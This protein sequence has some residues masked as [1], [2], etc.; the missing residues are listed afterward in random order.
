MCPEVGVCRELK[1]SDLHPVAYVAR[2]LWACVFRCNLFCFQTTYMEPYC[3]DYCWPL[4]GIN[5]AVKESYGK[6][7]V[8]CRPLVGQNIS[9]FMTDFILR[10][11]ISKKPCAPL[12]PPPCHFAKHLFPLAKGL[13]CSG[14][15]SVPLKWQVKLSACLNN[16]R[17]ERYTAR[18]RA[19]ESKGQFRVC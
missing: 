19:A 1:R 3:A 9:P 16:F 8:M 17:A 14:G 18:T 12:C 2:K 10:L 6:F 13:W 4:K 7:D 15:D 5:K 11:A